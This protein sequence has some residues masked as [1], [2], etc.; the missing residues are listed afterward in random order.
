MKIAIQVNL[1]RE[2]AFDVTNDVCRELENLGTE[3]YM[4]SSLKEYF[5]DFPIIFYENEDVL[6]E[7]D[8]FI[9]IGGDGTIIHAAHDAAKFDKEIL[10]INAGN[11]GF[12]AGL[13][14]HEL[15]LL[16]N[17]I[18]KNYT[19]DKRMMLCVEH[20]INGK[21][22]SKHYCLND[23]VVARGNS[24]RLCD[25][26]V[27]CNGNSVNDYFADGVILATPTGSTAYSLSAGGP[28]VEPTIESIIL[29]PICTHSLFARSLIFRPES[30]LTVK[31][32][33]PELCSP[34]ISCDGENSAEIKEGST[35]VI[36]R[37]NRYS[38]IIRIKAE[39]FTDV[40]SKKMIERRI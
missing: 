3:I 18:D 32:G 34:L 27:E 16:K 5:S 14:K 8:L 6:A 30:Q 25:I 40:L 21:L 15:H 37:A 22:V 31:I 36:R 11:L 9:A 26:S 23:A 28:V 24:L 39:S 33:N 38:K 7:C 20:Y 35:L 13:E 17:L 1:T 4:E 12:L 29:T 10:G 2:Y 19:I